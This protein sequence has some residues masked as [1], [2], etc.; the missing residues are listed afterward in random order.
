MQNLTAADILAEKP[1][2][3][4][5]ILLGKRAWLRYM[6]FDDQAEVANFSEGED[7]KETDALK[8]I[9]VLTL[10]DESGERIFKDTE[11]GMQAL[12]KIAV[13]DLWEAAQTAQDHNEMDQDK[14]QK[15]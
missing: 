2:L 3:R 14:A 9:L 1:K 12:G 13:I 5:I 11:L 10:A 6:S 4:E 15:K 7:A 8:L